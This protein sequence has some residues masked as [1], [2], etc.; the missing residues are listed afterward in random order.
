TRATAA[1]AV[2][3]TRALEAA[4]AESEPCTATIAAPVADTTIAAQITTRTRSRTSEPPRTS[5]GS[6]TAPSAHTSAGASTPAETSGPSRWWTV[7]DSEL[8]QA[9]GGATPDTSGR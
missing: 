9:C 5:H 8:I 3:P 1:A 7:V 2:A 6:V 4:P